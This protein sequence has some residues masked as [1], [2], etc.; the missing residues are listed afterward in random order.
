M[1]AKCL[2]PACSANFR[3]LRDGRLFVKEL[4][5]GYH[6]DGGEHHHRLGYFWLCG[7]CCRSMSVIAE[8]GKGVRAVPSR[9]QPPR[10]EDAYAAN[11]DH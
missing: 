1:V 4:D 8:K 3:T 7:S 11:N 2:N 9:P 6:E 10:G 5:D